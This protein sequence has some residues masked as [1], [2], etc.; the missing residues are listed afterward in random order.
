[1]CL[2][3]PGKIVAIDASQPEFPKARVLFDQV[4]RTVELSLLP[5]AKC[6]QYVIV[7]VGFA[8]SLLDETVA[9][10]RLALLKEALAHEK[11]VEQKP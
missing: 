3:L 9:L 5:E 8:I 7:H 6:G 4:E 2:A 1:M 11:M 10:A